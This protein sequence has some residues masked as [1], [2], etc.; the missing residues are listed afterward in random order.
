MSEHLKKKI[1]AIWAE[2]QNHLIGANQTMPWHL[3][4][5]LAH[6]K[7]TTMEAAVLMGRKTFDGMGRRVLPGR[8]L[9]ILTHD[10]GYQVDGVQTVSSIEEVLSWFEQQEKDLYIAGG[11]G[12][13]KAFERYF[14]VL[15]KTSVQ[16]KFK[17]DTYFPDIQ[18][19]NYQLISEEVY[20]KDDKNPFDFTVSVLRKL[21]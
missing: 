4:A 8:E 9:L 19:D 14:D 3:P 13:Y 11:A 16:A 6:F 15:I 10:K 12:V 20:Q 1:I 17:G 2:D 7:R 21:K 18:Q 5:E